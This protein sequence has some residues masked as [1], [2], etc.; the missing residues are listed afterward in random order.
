MSG[1]HFEYKQ[2]HLGNIADSIDEIVIGEA[3]EV[4]NWETNEEAPMRDSFEEATITEFKNA[5]EALRLAATYV[6]RID[7]LLSGD[8]SEAS[9]HRRLAA[10]L[11][12]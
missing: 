10:D 12:E 5:V 11:K 9:F 7:W 6:H 3:T 2:F 4:I 1:G 8:D